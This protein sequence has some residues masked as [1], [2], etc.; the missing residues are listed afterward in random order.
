[1]IV[2]ELVFWVV[3]A[4]AFSKVYFTA[5]LGFMTAPTI[6]KDNPM[7]INNTPSTITAK[8]VPVRKVF[9]VNEIVFDDNI[10]TLLLNLQVSVSS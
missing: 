9:V 10:E 2:S 1:M 6:P 8:N 5:S 7:T 4:R 3:F